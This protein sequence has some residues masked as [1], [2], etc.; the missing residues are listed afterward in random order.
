[1]EQGRGVGVEVRSG[2]ADDLSSLVPLAGSPDRAWWRS[3][4]AGAGREALLVAE[5]AGEALGLVSVRWQG[6]CD[7]PHPWLYG[8]HV[9]PDTRR[10]GIGTLLVRAAHA[11]AADRGARAVSL[12]VDRGETGLVRWYEALGYRRIRPHDHRWAALDPGTG[13]VTASGTS[14]TWLMRLTLP[15]SAT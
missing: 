8:L 3:D 7:P 15:S 14:P 2:R 4:A 9:R 11:V 12:D 5:R 6:E 13:R 1:M 10:A